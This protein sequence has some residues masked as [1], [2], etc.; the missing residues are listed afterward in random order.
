MYIMQ[1]DKPVCK[2]VHDTHQF[3]SNC[4]Y[5]YLWLGVLSVTNWNLCDVW[6]NDALS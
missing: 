3:S 5:M 2:Q 6:M 1:S 4:A